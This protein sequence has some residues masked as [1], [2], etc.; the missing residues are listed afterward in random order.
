ML[1][2]AN[3]IKVSSYEGTDTTG[4][5]TNVIGLNVDIKDKHVLIVEDIIDTGIK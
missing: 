2:I 1:K 3:F 5:V 4:T